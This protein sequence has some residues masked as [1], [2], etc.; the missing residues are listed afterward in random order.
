MRIESIVRRGA[1]NTHDFYDFGLEAVGIG[2]GIRIV[3][4]DRIQ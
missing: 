4:T 2:W 3:E 1:T